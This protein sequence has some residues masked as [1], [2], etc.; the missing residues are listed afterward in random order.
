MTSVYSVCYTLSCTGWMFIS[1]GH[2]TFGWQMSGQQVLT[3]TLILT[4]T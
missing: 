2:Q 3:L 1:E 4:L